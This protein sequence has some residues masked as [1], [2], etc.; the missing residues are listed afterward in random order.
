MAI[1]LTFSISFYILYNEQ[2]Y[3][4]LLFSFY[5]NFSLPTRDWKL[6]LLLPYL[7]TG[8]QV[9]ELLWPHSVPPHYTCKECCACMLLCAASL[10]TAEYFLLVVNSFNY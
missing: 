3:N 5:P 1:I 8:R 7:S 4:L 2:V 6:T 9:P 10:C